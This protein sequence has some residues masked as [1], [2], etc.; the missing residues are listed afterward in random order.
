MFTISDQ[1]FFETLLMKIRG[2]TIAYSS[3]KKRKER[4]VENKFMKTID[5]LEKDAD[6]IANYINKLENLKNEL[7]LLRIKKVEGLIVR[8]KAQWIHI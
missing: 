5:N 3:F 1:L 4:E 7:E 6:N 2:K 8:S